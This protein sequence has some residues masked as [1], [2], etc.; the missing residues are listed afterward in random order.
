MIKIIENN[1]VISFGWFSMVPRESIDLICKDKAR[2]ISYS[3]EEIFE[4]KDYKILT[5]WDKM[6]EMNIWD[7]KKSYKSNLSVTDGVQ[8]NLELKSRYGKNVISRAYNEF[9]RNFK[10]FIKEINYLSGI[11]IFNE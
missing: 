4:V 7:W 6:D 5:F 8:W 3:G 1:E 9:P 11:K 2:L 10:T